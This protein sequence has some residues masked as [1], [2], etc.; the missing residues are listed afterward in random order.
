[1]DAHNSEPFLPG[2]IGTGALRQPRKVL[3]VDGALLR[4]PDSPGGRDHRYPVVCEEAVGA[5]EGG[6]TEKRLSR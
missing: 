5:T 3:R 2:G 1:M 4:F 6:K